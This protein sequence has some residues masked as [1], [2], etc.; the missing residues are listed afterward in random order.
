[1]S[2]GLERP[3]EGGTV[4]IVA[5]LLFPVLLLVLAASTA[6]TAQAADPGKL[7]ARKSATGEMAALML[8]VKLKSPKAIY[9]RLDGNIA[10]GEV[11]IT[12][13]RDD[14]GI[15]EMKKVAKGYE[16]KRR[17]L[18][19]V[20]IAPAHAQRCEMSLGVGGSGHAS[21]EIRVVR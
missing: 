6:A 2:C 7:V 4:V 12:C 13:S 21:A 3:F 17:G 11:R 8:E 18:F 15:P 9:I 1:M 10:Y 19:R 16:Y 20:P 14:D 5:R